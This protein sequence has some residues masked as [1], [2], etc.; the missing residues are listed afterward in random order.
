[1]GVLGTLLGLRYRAPALVPATVVAVAWG[2]AVG[3]T[4]HNTFGQVTLMA[5]LLAAVLHTFYLL[6]LSW[7]FPR[8]NR[9]KEPADSS[10]PQVAQVRCREARADRPVAKSSSDALECQ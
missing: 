4:A 8:Y 9:C 1:M 10:R 6:A 2:I 3:W 7:R 5:A